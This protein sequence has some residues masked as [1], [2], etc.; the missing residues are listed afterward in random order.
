MN[1]QPSGENRFDSALAEIKQFCE[2]RDWS[3]FHNPKDV[4]L[5][6]SIESIEL[7]ELF[8]WK[9]GLESHEMLESP[10][11]KLKAEQEVADILFFL[12]LFCDKSNI[13]MWQ[14]LEEK[15]VSNRSKYPVERVKGKNKKYNEYSEYKSSDSVPSDKS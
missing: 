11:T 15:M 3:Q 8:R 6:L 14:A 9:T 5:A 10:D 13:D 4:A 1:D 7:V 12:L 2:E